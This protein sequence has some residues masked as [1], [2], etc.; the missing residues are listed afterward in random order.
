VR[1]SLS[2]E[3]R[4]ALQ[5]LLSVVVLK[6]KYPASYNFN[7]SGDDEQAFDESRIVGFPPIYY[8]YFSVSLL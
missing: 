3:K 1:G 5:N 8:Y 7:K 4:S 6:M 2:S